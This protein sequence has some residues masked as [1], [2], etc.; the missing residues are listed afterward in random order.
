MPTIPMRSSGTHICDGMDT[1]L[2]NGG[3]RLIAKAMPDSIVPSELYQCKL[4]SPQVETRKYPSAIPSLGLIRM[5][6]IGH[7]SRDAHVRTH[8]IKAIPITE[9]FDKSWFPRKPLATVVRR[10]CIDT[11]FRSTSP[12]YVPPSLPECKCNLLFGELRLPHRLSLAPRVQASGRSPGRSDAEFRL[13][14]ARRV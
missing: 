2:W 10:V 14:V 11:H 8:L 9:R 3:N 6:A 13:R 1:V 4:W 5:S 7:G 12:T